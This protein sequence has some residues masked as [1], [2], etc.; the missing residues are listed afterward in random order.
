MLRERGAEVVYIEQ[1]L[2]EC[3]QSADTRIAF[4]KRY[5]EEHHYTTGTVA[6]EMQKYLQTLS[7]KDLVQTIYAGIRRDALDLKH[8]SLDEVAGTAAEDPF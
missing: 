6:Q 7:V 8:T 1:L 3:L 5:L 2:A 4:I